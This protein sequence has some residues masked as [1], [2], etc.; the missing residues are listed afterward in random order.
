MSTER[1]MS[2]EAFVIERA[3]NGI[4]VRPH[5]GWWSE[6][7]NRGFQVTEVRVFNSLTDF[8]QW[9]AQWFPRQDAAT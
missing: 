4:I 8:E 2:Y 6:D 3:L 7:R 5:T 9:F 1:L